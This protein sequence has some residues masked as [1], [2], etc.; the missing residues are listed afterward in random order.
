[1]PTNGV[2]WNEL[3]AGSSL[4]ASESSRLARSGFSRFGDEA[5]RARRIEHLRGAVEAGTYHVDSHTIADRLIERGALDGHDD[6][7]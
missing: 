5:E 6:E 2:K 4:V 1:M 3:P 7:R